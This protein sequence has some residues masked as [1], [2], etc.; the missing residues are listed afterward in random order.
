MAITKKSG[1][2]SPVSLQ[3]IELIGTKCPNSPRLLIAY[4]VLARFAG[5]QPVGAHGSNMV[6]GAGASAV[7]EAMKMRWSRANELVRQLMELGIIRRAEKHLIVGKSPATYVMQ[8]QGDVDFP[9]SLVDGLNEVPGAVRLFDSVENTSLETIAAALLAL[10]HCY[11]LH[12]MNQW[13]GVCPNLFQTKWVISS[14][15][16]EGRGF[17]VRAARGTTDLPELNEDFDTVDSR[18][19]EIQ[20]QNLTT[21]MPALKDGFRLL[22]SSGLVYET[23]TLFDSKQQP[24]LPVRINDLYASQSQSEQSYIEAIPGAGFYNHFDNAERKREGVYFLM[25]FDPAQEGYLMIGVMRLRFRCSDPETAKGLERDALALKRVK[26]RL[27]ALDLV[28]DFEL[29]A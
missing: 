21:S 12:D 9:H 26:N 6:T 3:A 22:L 11:R 7:A 14:V 17:K 10:V 23:V 24:L 4:L 29:A 27:V 19:T 15:E 20:A 8:F 16:P 28:D 5:M 13:G 1:V 25:P 18:L 2:Y